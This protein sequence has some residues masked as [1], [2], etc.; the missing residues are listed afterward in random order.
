MTFKL[1]G[2]RFILS[3]RLMRAYKRLIFTIGWKRNYEK[4][5]EPAQM[6]LPLGEP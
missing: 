6:K 1:L 3:V 2:E 4:R 5:S